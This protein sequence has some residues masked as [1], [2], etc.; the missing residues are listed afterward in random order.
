MAVSAAEGLELVVREE[1]GDATTIVMFG[2]EEMKMRG[3]IVCWGFKVELC[4]F[5][6]LKEIESMEIILFYFIFL[7]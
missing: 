5:I 3:K 4:V 2:F 1:L 6:V 7:D